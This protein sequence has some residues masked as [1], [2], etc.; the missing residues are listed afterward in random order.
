MSRYTRFDA[1]DRFAPHGS[2][3]YR[4]KRLEGVA[5]EARNIRRVSTVT[6]FAKWIAAI[7]GVIFVLSLV[8]PACTGYF[9]EK[10]ATVTVNDKECVDH[11]DSDTGCTYLIFTDQGTFQVSDALFGTTRFNSSD[12]YGRI[13]K[14][15][16]YRITYY[17]WR[18]GFTSSYPNI[19]TIEEVAP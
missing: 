4:S 2:E 8:L 1:E 11:G 10:S 5:R 17:G 9:T 6:H 16:T 19:K 14:G 18:F 15:K 7:V 13:Q 12:L 3:V